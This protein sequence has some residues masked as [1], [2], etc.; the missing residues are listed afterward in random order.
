M[1]SDLQ[2]SLDF[3]PP[4]AAWIELACIN[5]II[6]RLI[7]H[8]SRMGETQKIFDM[9]MACHTQDEIAE[10]TGSKQQTVGDEIAT[11]TEIGNVSNFGKSLDFTRDN[12]FQPPLYN[13]WTFAK[14]TNGVSHFGNSEQRIVDNLLYLY[15]EPFDIV[16]DPFAGGGSTIDACKYR[17]RRYWVSDRKPIPEREKEIRKHDLMVDG[18]PPL[19][20]NWSNVALT[21]LDPPYW[22]QAAGMYSNDPTDLANMPLEDFT[23]AMVDLVKGIA[24][25]QSK[26]VIALIIQPTQ[27]KSDGKQFADHVLDIV[28]GVGNK[29]LVLENRVSCPYSTEQYNA[30]QVTWAKENKKLLVVTRELIVW[31]IA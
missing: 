4:P 11:F 28:A 9:W 30:Q 2:Q 10:A 1:V 21:Y 14:K 6:I 26:G 20:R 19:N 27:W 17:L 31:R 15:T 16:V 8:H 3:T 7:P 24:S 5:L 12:E 29:K 25:K 18:L 22:R 23:K 13:L